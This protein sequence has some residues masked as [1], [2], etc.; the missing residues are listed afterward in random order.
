M[1][2]ELKELITIGRDTNKLMIRLAKILTI[3]NVVN[4]LTIVVIVTVVLLR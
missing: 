4:V 1:E 3:L 2:K